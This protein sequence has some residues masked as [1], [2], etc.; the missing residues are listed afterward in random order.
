MSPLAVT[1]ASPRTEH[2]IV[3]KHACIAEDTW[4]SIAEFFYPRAQ[5][6]QALRAYNRQHPRASD[7]LHAEGTIVPGETVFIPSLA[8]LERHGYQP[9]PSAPAS[10]G[11]A[12]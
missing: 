8:V 3:E 10:P 11:Q 4:D 7:R 9:I 6:G 1:A 5:A 12:P 2:Y